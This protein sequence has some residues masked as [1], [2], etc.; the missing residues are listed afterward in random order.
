MLKALGFHRTHRVEPFDGGPYYEAKREKISLFRKVKKTR[1][2]GEAVSKK[3]N[4]SLLLLERKGK[5]RAS[6]GFCENR[7]GALLLDKPTQKLLRLK[8][9]E[10]ILF[11]PFK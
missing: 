11:V 5:I 7:N 9:G 2:Q 6:V 4:G 8:R 3:G 10:T 1:F